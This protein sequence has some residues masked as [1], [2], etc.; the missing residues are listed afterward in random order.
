MC[1]SLS[2]P[3]YC[4]CKYHLLV[5]SMFI[6]SLNSK[7][8]TFHSPLFFL[9]RTLMHPFSAFQNYYYYY[10]YYYYYCML[11][12]IFY[13][14]LN[15]GEFSPFTGILSILADSVHSSSGFPFLQSPFQA[16]EDRS[17]N[18]NYNWYHLHPHIPQFFQFFGNILVSTFS[19]LFSLRLNSKIY[20]LASSVF[21]W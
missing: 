9:L 16:F 21:L 20:E 3:D 7:W 18:T 17:K 1:F 10:H 19:L 8:I 15:E 2:R 6:P 12:L 5:G 14:K 11:A 4:L 13:Q